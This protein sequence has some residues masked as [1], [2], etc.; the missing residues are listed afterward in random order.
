MTNKFLNETA[1]L[2]RI[3]SKKLIVYGAG[4]IGRKTYK[5]LKTVG[6]YTCF[7]WDNKADT[8]HNIDNIVVCK[9]H[10][11][12]LKDKAQYIIIVT[13]YAEN[14]SKMIH[15]ELVQAGFIDVISDKSFIS[16]LIY[17][18]CKKNISQN[19]FAFDMKSCHLCPVPKDR[20]SGCNIFDRYV[21]MN[22]AKGVTNFDTDS[23]FAI[24]SIG[25]LVTNKCTLKCKGCN[26]LRDL[27][28][29]DHNIEVPR[30]DIKNDLL[31]IIDVVDFIKTVVV[32][33]GEAFLHREIYNIFSDLL[34]LPKIGIIHIITNGTVIPKNEKVLE[35]LSNPRV[36]LEVS[37]Y[38]DK[39]PNKMQ[40]N[41]K[42]FLS[43]LFEYNIN[44]LYMPQVL[45]W[46]DFGG[47]EERAYSQEELIHIF[48]SCCFVSNDIFCGKLHKCS[49]SLF[50]NYLKII[51]D[52]ISDYVD[53]RQT[54]KEVLREKL[55]AFFSKQ[56]VEAC[57]FCNGT[58]T[59][60]IEAGCQ[61]DSSENIYKINAAR[62]KSKWPSN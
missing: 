11:H 7:F 17:A 16:S 57:R 18:E 15:N 40:D 9:P 29:T 62:E 44:H 30:M 52:F 28:A 27:Y 37:N 59:V 26:H 34:S 21:A 46:Y 55:I 13:I 31:K 58:S 56:Y 12:S 20:E 35:L 2:Q 23:S 45:Q 47:Y 33:G 4:K 43:K 8:I 5:A 41:V 60:T 42:K 54:P 61:L 50:A 51:P 1:I 53:I 36:I 39:I 25:I 3:G 6:I 10:F 38:G 32:V 14:I 24:S 22:L 19:S 48:S 49:R